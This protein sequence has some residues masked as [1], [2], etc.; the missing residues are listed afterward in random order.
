MTVSR[1]TSWR[2]LC[3]KADPDF[4]RSAR[5]VTEYEFSMGRTMG[6][7]R[8][9]RNGRRIFEG[10]YARRGAY[11][12]VTVPADALTDNGVPIMDEGQFLTDNVDE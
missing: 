3:L 5:V 2:E 10:D 4:A 6:D 9:H 11:T 12:P 8:V 7:E 1:Q